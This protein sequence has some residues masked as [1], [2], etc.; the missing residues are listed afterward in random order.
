MLLEQTQQKLIAMKLYGMANAI[1]E[2]L[3]RLD[4]QSW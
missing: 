2:R 4:H 3:T 1:K